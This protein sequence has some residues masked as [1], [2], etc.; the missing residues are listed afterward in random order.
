MPAPNHNYTLNKS[1]QFAVLYVNKLTGSR[2]IVSS[3]VKIERARAM[4]QAEAKSLPGAAW[5]L[6]VVK[7]KVPGRYLGFRDPHF[8]E[9]EILAGPFSGGA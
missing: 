3:H 6:Y 1:L 4:A 8:D 2:R 7:L 5:K 9:F